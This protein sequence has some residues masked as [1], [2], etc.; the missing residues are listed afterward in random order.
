MESHS[1][2]AL[3]DL[4]MQAPAAIAVIRGPNHV[5]DFA[6]PFYLRLVSKTKAIRG[7]TV[8]QVL[9]ELEGQGFFELL[10]SV[11]K[12]GEPFVGTA[13]PIDMDQDGNGSLVR[14]YLNF[15]YQP[16]K[17]DDDAVYGIMAH[18]VD[19]T[20]EVE[21]KL[22]V[23]ED[24]ERY[25]TLFNTINQGFCII[26]VIFDKN[27]VARDYIFLEVNHVFEEQTGLKHVIGKTARTVIP[28]LEDGWVAIYGEVARTGKAASFTESSDALGRWYEVVATPLGNS[29]SNRVAI[30]FTDITQRKK[31]EDALRQSEARNRAVV[32]ALEEGVTVLDSEGV[33]VSANRS[34]ERLLGLT[35]KQM[36]G[37]NSLDSH[38]KSVYEDG[39][40][41]PGSEHAPQHVLRTKKSYNNQTMGIYKPDGNVVWLN[42]NAQPIIDDGQFTGIV[43]SFFDITE[44]KN[45]QEALQRQ[46]Q[47]TETIS[48]I[49]SSCLFMIDSDGLV[50]YMNP[51]ATRVTGY[52]LKESLGRPMHELIHHSRPDGT[53]YPE[54]DC[55][56]VN[57]YRHGKL[58]TLHEDIFYR[59][60]GSTFPALISGTPIP[61]KKGVKATVV[62][63]RDIEEIK[64]T[65]KRNDE[66]E[67]RTALLKE[68]R[69]QLVALNNAK[70]D[71][72]AI[73]S[74]QLRTPATAVKQYL[75][76]VLHGFT[77]PLTESQSKF[78][79]TAY[80]SNERQ[81]N[82]ITDL[83]RTAKI[84]SKQYALKKELVPIVDI[85]EAVIT[86]MQPGLDIKSQ[87]VQFKKPTGPLR[88]MIDPMEIK[89]VLLNL[90]ENASKYSY[91]QSVIKIALKK[92]KGQVHIEITDSGVGIS[93]ASLGKIFDKFT[94]INNELSDT[95]TGT[96]LGLYWVKKIIKLHNGSVDVTSKLGS[97]STFK[98]SLP[99]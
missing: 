14:N 40:T 73:A 72:I 18:A 20:A 4:F 22:Q 10:D 34:A 87:L 7:Q 21:A 70:D 31:T 75:G 99:L 92:N 95:V 54:S 13:L 98:V 46:L 3:Y 56:L 74:H 68:Q 94:R 24:E 19:V 47:I 26:E 88:V 51:A 67:E 58:N 85:I 48:E 32:E 12:S 11:Y 60:D 64:N 29:E 27:N 39:T 33:I 78:L 45:T 36:Q 44:R 89:L 80:D 59:K 1:N 43:A 96:G 86:D 71:F 17:D 91:P 8:R 52:A 28:N 57:T 55:P 38:W 63:F 77:E 23:R 30:L 93:D 42:V 84:D 35:L 81:L 16:L 53:A 61:V 6:N 9:P 66:L 37:R 25:R 83:L 49:A 5:F 82:I 65:L 69:S 62:E 2:R 50:T 15:V 76:L 79:S 97:G 41:M 90:L